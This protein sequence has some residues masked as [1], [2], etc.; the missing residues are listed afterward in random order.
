MRGHLVGFYFCRVLLSG[1]A[2]YLV[3]FSSSA[4]TDLSRDE[5]FERTKGNMWMFYTSRHGDF[6][7][8]GCEY[9]KCHGRKVGSDDDT[10]WLCHD[11]LY[12]P[13]PPQVRKT[14]GVTH[15]LLIMEEVLLSK[16]L[17]IMEKLME[18]GGGGMKGRSILVVTIK[19]SWSFHNVPNYS[20]D[21]PHWPPIFF[22]PTFKL[23]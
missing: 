19:F 8:T 5:V 21:L 18:M 17:N 9:F 4:R 13:S 11:K 14:W 6:F 2:L 23:C 16:V 7:P 10:F 1:I 22:S 3:A 12:I 15:V 20:I